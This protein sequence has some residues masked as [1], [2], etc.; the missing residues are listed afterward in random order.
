[1]QTLH[2]TEGRSW[3]DEFKCKKQFLPGEFLKMMISIELLNLFSQTQV[4][5]SM[6]KMWSMLGAS[7]IY[8]AYNNNGPSSKCDYNYTRKII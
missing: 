4:N 2:K 5:W 7:S 1:M 3:S 8:V 6:I